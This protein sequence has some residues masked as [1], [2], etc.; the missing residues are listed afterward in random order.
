MTLQ[1]DRSANARRPRKG[2][3]L[4]MAFLMIILL[5]A[6]V[7]QLSYGTKAD[8]RVTENDVTI[9]QMDMAIESALQEVY[10]SLAQDAAAS[11]GGGEAAGGMA[12]PTG[13]GAPGA[14]GDGQQGQNQ[15]ADSRMDSWGRPQRSTIGDIE[16]RILVQDEDGKLNV[17]QLLFEDEEESEKALERVARLIDFFRDGSTVDVDRSEAV[18]IAQA[19]REHLRNR[20]NSVLPRAKQMSDLEDNRERALP[21]TLKEFE[22]LKRFEP[23]LFRDFRDERG[24]IVHSLGSYLSVWTSVQ[25]GS[26]QED[27]TGAGALEAQKDPNGAGAGG[28]GSGQD[29]D[30][31][32][33]V[34]VNVN[35]APVAVLKALVDDRTVAP[36]F[37]DSVVEYRNLEKQDEEGAEGETEEAEPQLD[38]YGEEVV[39]R[40]I[41]DTMEEVEDVDG[42]ERLD[43]GAKDD[44]RSLLCVRSHVFSIYITARR[45]TGASDDFGGTLGVPRPG[46]RE[47]ERGKGLVRTV[48]SVVWRKT[49]GETTQI[50]PLVRWEVLDYTPFEVIDFPVEGR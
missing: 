49:D 30:P 34:C 10:D 22:V 7:F 13:G 14:G 40:E 32:W 46:E 16:L 9:T 45:K 17:L 15:P 12:P 37:W 26:S 50:V 21:M 6:I 44:L 29:N 43:D 25:Q 8:L 38:E 4:L 48:R 35:T 24:E 39:E 33:G 42:W 27:A 47:D 41:F 3:A 2:S 36:R 11:E 1:R 28:Q 23:S 20:L 31:N 18:R 5:Y 19:M